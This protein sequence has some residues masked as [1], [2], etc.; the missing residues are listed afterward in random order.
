MSNDTDNYQGPLPNSDHE[1]IIATYHLILAHS[2]RLKNLE[3]LPAKVAKLQSDVDWH[4]RVLGALGV[5][6]GGCAVFVATHLGIH[7]GT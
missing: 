3:E 5:V 1:Y 7:V 4:N 6:A 2:G